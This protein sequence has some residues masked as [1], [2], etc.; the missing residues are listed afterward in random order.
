MWSENRLQH[1]SLMEIFDTLII[2]LVRYGAAT[3]VTL[4]A[5]AGV[6]A[7]GSLDEHLG[8]TLLI[9]ALLAVV[10]LITDAFAPEG[11]AALFAV[12]G[13]LLVSVPLGE[14]S[15]L[16]VEVSGWWGYLL[17]TV[18]ILTVAFQVGRVPQTWLN[19][20]SA[21]RPAILFGGFV[22]AF[23]G[24]WLAQAVLGGVEMTATSGEQLATLVVLAALFRFGGGNFLYYIQFDGLARI[25]PSVITPT[26]VCGLKLWALAWLSTWMAATL[27]IDGFGMFALATLIVTVVTAPIWLYEQVA[28]EDAMIEEAYGRQQEMAYQQAMMNLSVMSA[29]GAARSA[30]RLA[31]EHRRRQWYG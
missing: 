13:A 19:G 28:R 7:G 15:G 21:G 20:Y 1:L 31:E 16:R 26:V 29:L 22:L 3:W 9:A 12:P 24:L 30:S 27:R 25:L 17:A 10:L 18:A 11:V 23:A 8:V 5:G 2:R 4:A 6:Q 14:A